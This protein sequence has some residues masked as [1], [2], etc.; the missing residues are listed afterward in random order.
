MKNKYQTIYCP[1]CGAGN[2]LGD[3]KCFSCSSVLPY[4]YG[5]QN[6]PPYPYQQQLPPVKTTFL[7]VICAITVVISIFLSVTSLW[8]IA[9]ICMLFWLIVYVCLVNHYKYSGRDIK[10][11][12]TTRN[13]I[14]IVFILTFGISITFS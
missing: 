4:N 6:Q 10:S 11:L 12:T 8:T 3:P 13:T 2:I 14:C 1:K 5:A 7:D 9:Y